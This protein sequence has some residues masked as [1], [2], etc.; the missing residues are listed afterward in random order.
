[1]PVIGHVPGPDGIVLAAVSRND[2]KIRWLGAGAAL[3]IQE[4]HFVGRLNDLRGRTHAWYAVRLAHEDRVFLVRIHIQVLNTIPVL[5]LVE[6]SAGIYPPRELAVVRLV[7]VFVT[8][9]LVGSAPTRGDVRGD[10]PVLLLGLAASASA[11]SAPHAAKVRLS[12][13]R[14]R[15][16]DGRR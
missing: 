2:A 3:R 1:M 4:D 6:R 16:R 14:V 5:R 10:I 12:V 7:R 11:A 15:G 13:R 9:D 8:F